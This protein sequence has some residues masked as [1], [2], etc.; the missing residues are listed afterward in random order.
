[1]YEPSTN[2]LF[3]YV[4]VMKVK[5]VRRL[6]IIRKYISITVKK[7]YCRWIDRTSTE[8]LASVLFP[9]VITQFT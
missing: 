6:L 1:V 8:V 5:T 2:I 9:F 3:V 7:T 4:Q